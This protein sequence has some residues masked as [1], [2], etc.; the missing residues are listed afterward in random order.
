MHILIVINLTKD[1]GYGVVLCAPVA[2]LA[3]LLLHLRKSEITRLP[4]KL[5]NLL[6]DDFLFI[7][8]VQFIVC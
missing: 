6:N 7:M 1:Y 2:K 5:F 8:V 3:K 4:S